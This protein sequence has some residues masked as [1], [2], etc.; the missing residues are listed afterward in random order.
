[1]KKIIVWVIACFIFSTYVS[2]ALAENN[3]VAHKDPHG[4][5]IAHPQGWQVKLLGSG[6]IVVSEDTDNLIGPTAIIWT[7]SLKNPASSK[8]VLESLVNIIKLTNP[9][10]NITSERGLDTKTKDTVLKADYT[11]LLTGLNYKMFLMCSVDNK[12][13]MVSGFFAP[14][15]SYSVEKITLVRIL[16][17]FKIEPS[18]RDP[19]RTAPPAKDFVL[20]RDPNEGA[21]TLLVPKGWLVRGGLTRPYVD[22]AVALEIKKDASAKT[23]IYFEQPATPTF[24][25]PNQTLAMAGFVEGSKYNA[26]YGAAQ[27]SIVMRYLGAAGYLQNYFLPK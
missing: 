8:E 15:D 3:F 25:E 13:V 26:S 27:D 22:A 23:A 9:T 6:C 14:T 11:E 19:K 21:F 1:M 4:F 24:T 7:M 2:L 16:N 5:S 18:L 20:Y 17:S 12:N 10:F